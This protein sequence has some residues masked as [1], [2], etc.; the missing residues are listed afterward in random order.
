MQNRIKLLLISGLLFTSYITFADGSKNISKG[1]SQISK[2]SISIGEGASQLFSASVKGSVNF[3][4]DTV[5][6]TGD[7]AEVVLI[8]SA[9]ATAQSAIVTVS[10]ASSTV[11][12]LA[13]LAGSVIDI[14][15]V[16]AEGSATVLGYLL[17]NQN[18]VLLFVS[19]D[20]SSL[21]LRSSKL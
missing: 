3:V 15:Q 4:V 5:E 16:N 17:M 6:L 21:T 9:T 18:E 1:S 13:I 14:I 2:G 8:S 20:G 10:M 19:P 12:S 7:I 11:A